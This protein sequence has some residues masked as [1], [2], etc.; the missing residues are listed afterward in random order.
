MSN[1]ISEND[2]TV[3]LEAL[4]GMRIMDDVL[5]NE[6]V[7]RDKENGY[8]ALSVILRAFTGLNLKVRTAQ[9]QSML[10]GAGGRSIWLD[11][12]AEDEQ[13]RIIDLEMQR[14]VDAA[15]PKRAVDYYLAEPLTKT[16][17][18]DFTDGAT[19]EIVSVPREEIIRRRGELITPQEAASLNFLIQTG[20][21]ESILVTDQRRQATEYN[22]SYLKPYQ[23]IALV[24]RKREKLILE[25]QTVSLAMDVARD[26]IELNYKGDFT[27]I[28]A[29]ALLNV[30]LLNSNL[31]TL[32][33]AAMA[34]EEEGETGRFYKADAEI[35][36]KYLGEDEPREEKFTFIVKTLDVDTAKAAAAAWIA[37]REQE[38]QNTEEISSIKTTLT[39][40]TPFSCTAII[41]RAFC[42]AYR[43]IE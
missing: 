12:R 27:I 17:I 18:E 20:E 11:I 31:L 34:E 38:R 1:S 8:Q 26:W 9:V 24:N 39:A 23:V 41:P 43:E 2:I 3:F 29:S 5:M 40:A 19:G 36:I 6:F 21:I 25:A 14:A 13:G 37:A 16:W 32:E 15:L 10:T 7:K 35:K 28:G 4:K 22:N 33:E 30:I 42:E